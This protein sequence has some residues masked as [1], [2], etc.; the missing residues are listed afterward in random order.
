MNEPD[1]Q[2]VVPS[3]AQCQVLCQWLRD[4]QEL[5]RVKEDA[6]LLAHGRNPLPQTLPLREGKNDVGRFECFIPKKFYWSRRKKYGRELFTSDAGLKDL[7]R[8]HPDFFTETVSG[9]AVSGYGGCYDGRPV[10]PLRRVRFD[11]GTFQPAT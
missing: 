10:P 11:R 7:R 6:Q 5:A 3:P 9:K 1:G 8:H 2:L 4:E